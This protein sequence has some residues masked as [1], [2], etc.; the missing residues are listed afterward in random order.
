LPVLANVKQLSPTHKLNQFL[1]S[2][3]SH[4]LSHLHQALTMRAYFLAISLLV[5]NC[6]A[7]VPEAVYGGGFDHEKNDTIRLRIANGGAGQSGLIKG[8]AT[9]PEN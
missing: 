1:N 2:S 6:F 5:S 7:V 9:R 8:E 4:K 3:P